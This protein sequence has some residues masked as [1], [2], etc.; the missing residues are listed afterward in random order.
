M[1]RALDMAL[2]R[3]EIINAVMVDLGWSGGTRRYWSGVGDLDHG[4]ETYTGLG[5]LGQVTPVQSSP[6][7]EVIETK[8]QL[9]GVSA[10][11]LAALGDTVKGYQATLYEA[12]LDERYVVIER[13]EMLTARLDYQQYAVGDDGKATIAQVGSSGFWHLLNRSAAKW[14]PE[15]AKA[16]VA[17]ETGFDEMHLQQDTNLTW[18]PA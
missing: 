10:E 11:L 12:F 1:T 9:S 7:I 14:S 6:E 8:F 16:L 2:M 3:G 4:G 17:D 5:H 18:R 13:E 15:E